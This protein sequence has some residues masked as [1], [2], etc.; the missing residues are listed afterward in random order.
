[1]W[2]YNAEGQCGILNQ[3]YVSTPTLLH[4]NNWKEISLGRFHSMGIKTNETIWGWG[5][6]SN[7]EMGNNTLINPQVPFEIISTGWD[8][9]FL[10]VESSLATKTDGT[11]WATGVNNGHFGNADTLASLIFIPIPNATDWKQ[12]SLTANNT[13][14]I[15][16]DGTLWAWGPNNGE[17]GNGTNTGTNVPMQIGSTNDWKQL[18]AGETFVAA[19]K[20]DGSLWSWGN[21]DFGQLGNG[22]FS[23]SDVPLNVSCPTTMVLNTTAFD[24]NT[25]IT[26]YPNPVKNSL[27]IVTGSSQKITVVTVYSTLGQLVQSFSDANDLKSIDVSE[28]RPGIYFMK[29]VS[30]T[31]IVTK[32]FVKE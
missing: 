7:G 32:T 3:Y 30:N 1:M 17:F 6:N 25:A 19:I 24:A 13:F 15:K 31:G 2:G 26:I 4:G 10:G 9:V 16:N 22:T 8:K 23:F 11:L 12:L 27:N 21:N 20:T 29:L 18:S 28:L 14:G 5:S